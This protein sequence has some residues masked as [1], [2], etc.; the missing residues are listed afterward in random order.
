MTMNYDNPN[1]G[2]REL[3][4]VKSKPYQSVAMRIE[5]DIGDT[6]VTIVDSGNHISSSDG[7]LNINSLG[8]FTVSESIEDNMVQTPE[9]LEYRH[10]VGVSLASVPQL[11]MPAPDHVT[12]NLIQIVDRWLVKNER[13]PNKFKEWLTKRGKNYDD[14]DGMELLLLEAEFMPVKSFEVSSKYNAFASRN[15]NGH[16]G[17]GELIFDPYYYQKMPVRQNIA[18]QDTL[19]HEYDHT[20]NHYLVLADA[21]QRRVLAKGVTSYLN[22]LPEE[23]R[24]SAAEQFRPYLRGELRS[25]QQIVDDMVLSTTEPKFRSEEFLQRVIALSESIT[26][27]TENPALSS[28]KST[29]DMRLNQ[30]L[31]AYSLN[32]YYLQHDLEQNAKDVMQGVPTLDAQNIELE[33]LRRLVEEGTL[34]Q[35]QLLSKARKI[36]KLTREMSNLRQKH[37]ALMNGEPA[38]TVRAVAI[39]LDNLLWQSRYYAG[40]PPD[41][42]DRTKEVVE[43]FRNGFPTTYAFM[44]YEFGEGGMGDYT[45]RSL[46]YAQSPEETGTF[47]EVTTTYVEPGRESIRS[48]A[49]QTTNPEERKTARILTQLAY[50]EGKIGFEEYKYRM[51]IT[52]DKPEDYKYLI[53][54][55]HNLEF[56]DGQFVSKHTPRFQMT[57]DGELVARVAP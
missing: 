23:T 6:P 50:D 7:R 25:S 24:Q 38:Q 43:L 1:E 48:R 32:E 9:D 10:G 4:G 47:E 12:P 5:S 13:T 52:G 41:S 44:N 19:I 27:I 30:M 31:L 42:R 53:K 55:L 20:Q 49:T 26:A 35:D 33:E 39:T 28:S 34:P 17:L 45:V 18:V 54:T 2:W 37:G 11:N 46:L 51:G 22:T 3:E 14:L 56:K 36:M 16:M 57:K 8:D 40:L 15:N 21:F 29:A